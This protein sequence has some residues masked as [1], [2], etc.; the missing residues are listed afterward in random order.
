MPPL[1]S[2]LGVGLDT[3]VLPSA[4]RLATDRVATLGGDLARPFLAQGGSERAREILIQAIR[5]RGF[6]WFDA[7][8]GLA[9]GLDD[10][11]TL[12]TR[13]GLLTAAAHRRIAERLVDRVARRLA[14]L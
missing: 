13:D 2:A 4:D 5:D 14:A 8:E 11:A 9:E 3:V 6:A 1:I 10:P 7:A 12:F